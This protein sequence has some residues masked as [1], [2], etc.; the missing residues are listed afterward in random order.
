MGVH[1][2]A[3]ALGAN[4]FAIIC[5]AEPITVPWARLR[6]PC[7]VDSRPL[8]TPSCDTRPC[9]ASSTL[10]F[11]TGSA[12]RS[13]HRSAGCRGLPGRSLYAETVRAVANSMRFAMLQHVPGCVHAAPAGNGVAQRNRHTIGAQRSGPGISQP[14]RRMC[15][16]ARRHA[17]MPR[18]LCTS[19]SQPPIRA[20]SKR[21][22]PRFWQAG[23]R[24][25]HSSAELQPT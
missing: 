3:S 4:S 9:G 25:F 5:R 20:M 24:G 18:C 22:I 13:R 1:L 2:V 11:P 7:S 10:D 14:L 19:A 21:T 23:W 6:A 15:R 17:S 8:P 12:G 16:G